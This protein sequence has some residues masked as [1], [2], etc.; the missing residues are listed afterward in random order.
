MDGELVIVM[1]VF[2]DLPDDYRPQPTWKRVDKL[3]K[4]MHGREP[5]W[6]TVHRQVMSD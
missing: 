1:Y 6:E 5:K 4:F 2:N 3:T